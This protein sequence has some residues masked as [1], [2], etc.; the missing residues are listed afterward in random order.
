MLGIK[1]SP[2]IDIWSLGC[3][4]YEL[5]SGRPLF[6]GEDE[7]DQMLCIGEVRGLAPRSL[8]VIA[9]RRKLFYDDEY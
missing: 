6:T 3:I 4:L 7:L 1:Y 5:F 2:A 8:I 9:S